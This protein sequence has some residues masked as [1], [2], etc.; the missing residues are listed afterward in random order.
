[1]G[2]RI[3]GLMLEFK[4][5]GKCFVFVAVTIFVVLD[6]TGWYIA[7]ILKRGSFDDLK[8]I[9]IVRRRSIQDIY[10]C[11]LSIWVRTQTLRSRI[12]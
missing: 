1:M 5:G 9:L 12:S 11:T 6:W 7:D 4:S 10:Y 8:L 2:E 3:W